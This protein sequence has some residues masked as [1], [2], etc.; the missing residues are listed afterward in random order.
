M[1]LGIQHMIFRLSIELG[2]MLKLISSFFFLG[3]GKHAGK[4]IIFQLVAMLEISYGCEK[5]FY[6]Y[7]LETEDV[8]FSYIER[9][10]IHY[11]QTHESP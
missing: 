7:Q 5:A 11:I 1:V 10:N 2:G 3:G 6:F 8:Y 4:V 9:G